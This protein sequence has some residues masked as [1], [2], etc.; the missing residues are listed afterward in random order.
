MTGN[1][2]ALW[3]QDDNGNRFLVATLADEAEARARLVELSSL[4]HR[5]I[6]WIERETEPSAATGGA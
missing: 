1:R 3:R 5:Q 6:Y 2:Y 4:S